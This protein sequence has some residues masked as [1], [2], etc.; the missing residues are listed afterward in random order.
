MVLLR[1]LSRLIR[2][3]KVDDD[4]LANID[5]V[6]VLPGSGHLL[7]LSTFDLKAGIFTTTGEVVVAPATIGSPD[8]ALR[9]GEEPGLLDATLAVCA[10]GR[11]WLCE[12]LEGRDGCYVYA[13]RDGEVDS[14]ACLLPPANRGAPSATKPR[15]P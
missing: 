6:S 15:A 3:F 4:G 8:G 12:G 2:R 7:L 1:D 9:G 13:P 10:D 5:G 11:V 14:C